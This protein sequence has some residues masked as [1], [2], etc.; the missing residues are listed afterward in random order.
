MPS[1]NL[2]IASLVVVFLAVVASAWAEEIKF[3]GVFYPPGN[4]TPLILNCTLTRP[5]ATSNYTLAGDIRS[6]DGTY[7][8]S[9]TGY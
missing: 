1:P 6:D 7:T 2:R 8:V 9:G 5:D 4:G 3:I